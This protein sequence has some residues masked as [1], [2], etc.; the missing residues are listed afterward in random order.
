VVFDEPVSSVDTVT[1]RLVETAPVAEIFARPQP[2]Y[3]R[4]LIAA[5]PSLQAR[6]LG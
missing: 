1:R 5:I 4:R 6:R 2:E 3:T